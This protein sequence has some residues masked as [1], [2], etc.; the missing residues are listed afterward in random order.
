M[1]IT[2]FDSAETTQYQAEITT[3]KLVQPPGVGP[4]AVL[5]F[6]LDAKFCGK[7]PAELESRLAKH[8]FLCDQNWVP[9]HPSADSLK[10][11]IGYQPGREF[12]W[13]A[14]E[15]RHVLIRFGPPPSSGRH[16][17]VVE[18]KPDAQAPTDE[19]W[20]VVNRSRNTIMWKGE[21]ATFAHGAEFE[22]VARLIEKRGRWLTHH[23][24]EV[25]ILDDPEPSESN[26]VAALKYRSVS[27]LRASKLAELPSRIV[28]A[29][30][31]YRLSI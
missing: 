30:R 13:A 16:N 3:H 12:P 8:H 15:R 31:Q 14:L 5:N 6:V 1:S 23:E 21:S 18:I 28:S 2:V 24:I 10:R 26:R 27:R 22:F 4:T 9:V 25:E 29:T 20:P 7:A 11:I 19:E 17:P